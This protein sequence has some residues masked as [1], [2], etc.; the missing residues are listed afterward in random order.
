VLD[1]VPEHRLFDPPERRPRRPDLREDVHTVA[2]LLDHPDEAAD[3]PLDPA[4]PVELA[5]V[6]GVAML[7][8]PT[9]GLSR[10]VDVCLSHT[11]IPYPGT[12]H[13][14]KPAR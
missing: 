13:V 12:V 3:L 6:P 11:P 1:V 9:P 10:V 7:R 5:R 4:E 2:L 8:A 14:V